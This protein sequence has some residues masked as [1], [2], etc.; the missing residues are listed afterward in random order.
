MLVGDR[1][2]AINARAAIT[3]GLVRLHPM[4]LADG[5]YALPE[6]V[7]Y[8]AAHDLLSGW[9]TET[10]AP[11]AYLP[12]QVPIAPFFTARIGG[13]SY[14]PT[15]GIGGITEPA[16][17]V[18]RFEVKANDADSLSDSQGG[19]RR[20]EL[21]CTNTGRG[22][23]A[24]TVW[25]AFSVIRGPSDGMVPVVNGSWGL[26]HQWHSVDKG[27]PR[28]PVLA[29]DYSNNQLSIFTRSSANTSNGNGVAVRHY[30]AALPA[31]GVVKHFVIQSTFGEF[32]HLNV[33]INGLSAVNADVPIGYWTDLTDGSG[34]T[35]LGYPHWGL[36]QK[37]H[38]ETDV[39]YIANPEWG[40]ADLST[41][42]TTP[43]PVPDLSPWS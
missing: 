35:E 40:A 36:Y 32:G 24:E 14:Y 18:F 19:S 23:G 13:R 42:I 16:A 31:V 30:T 10:P 9:A 39:V 43:L 21:V 12:E 2:S 22:V 7:L 15:R 17:N 3:G 11:G 37:N 5:R 38:S 27:V 6:S 25:I 1:A 8:A 34:R 41:R 20:R 33:W 26:I 4:A 28:S 29:V